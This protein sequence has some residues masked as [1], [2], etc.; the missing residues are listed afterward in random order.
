MIVNKELLDNLC[1]DAGE[2]RTQKARMYKSLGR[3]EIIDVEYKNDRN[4]ELKAIV[5]GTDVYKT[6]ISVNNGEIDDITCNCQDYYNHYGVC[7]H[8]LATIMT[9]AENEKYIEKLSK[10]DKKIN[11]NNLQYRNFRQLVN[12]FYNEEIDEIDKDEKE[13]KNKGTIHIEPK[14]IYD[15]FLGDIKV[16][17]KIGNKRMYKIKNLSEFYTRMLE[18]EYYKY[19]EK[20]QFVHIKE[21]FDEESQSLV[22]FLLK[23]AEIIKYANSNSNSNYR[24]YGKA[25]SETSILLGNSGIDELFEILK[26]K[27][28]E[29]QKDY[30]TQKILFT[31]DNPKISFTLKK[32]EEDKYIIL[33]NTEIF[34]VSILKGKEYKYILDSNKLYRCSKEFENTNLKLL[35]FFRQNYMTEVSLGKDELTQLFSIIIPKV[36]AAIKIENMSEKEIERYKPKEL[37]VKVYLDFEEH[38]YLI[39][40]VLFCYDDNEFNQVGS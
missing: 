38:D 21:M 40:D 39:A 31:D 28:V 27:E 8:T 12:T 6:Y 16:E 30:S 22:Q 26:N 3:V 7:K 1:S 23:Y 10:Q 5:T 2:K 11:N 19:G 25:L 15:R 29:F 9:F 4:F 36:K 20:L 24:Y 17:F 33:P 18:K 13:L 34:N 14:V 35:E 32:I 37:R